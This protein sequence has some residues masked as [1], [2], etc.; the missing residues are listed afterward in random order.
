MRQPIKRKNIVIRTKYNTRIIYDMHL[1]NND[2]T[3]HIKP[4]SE[5]MRAQGLHLDQLDLGLKV[6]IREGSSK[7]FLN[8]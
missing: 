6:D 3:R 8:Q 7:R 5:E 1:P 4:E 2:E